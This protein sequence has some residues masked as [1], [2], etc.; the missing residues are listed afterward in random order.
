[1]KPRKN[2]D[3]PVI[4]KSECMAALRLVGRIL[5]RI[6]EQGDVPE[7]FVARASEFSS[8]LETLIREQHPAW[9]NAEDTVVIL[10]AWLPSFRKQVIATRR[11][12]A[13]SCGHTTKIRT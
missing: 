2:P 7:T 12:S 11:R 4:S 13:V 9:P 10:G 5:D 6:V 1:M 8:H 3:E